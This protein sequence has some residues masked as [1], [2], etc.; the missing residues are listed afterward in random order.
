M[1]ASIAT[2]ATTL[3]W[4]PPSAPVGSG[5]AA[6]STQISYNGQSVGQLDVQP[7]TMPGSLSIPLGIIQ[8]LKLLVI[9][10]L[11]S[12]EVSV[13]FNSISLSGTNLTVSSFSTPL[14]TFTGLSG[15]TAADV[16]SNI[17]VTGASTPANNGTFLI[18]SRLSSSSVTALNASA[19]ASDGNDGAINWSIN[20]GAAAFSVPPQGIVTYAVPTSP[21]T[22][23]ITSVVVVTTTM[24]SV[25]EQISYWTYGD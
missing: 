2:L 16:G 14:V 20:V 25:I 6:F 19:V 21:T 7:T 9:K 13:K 18:T 12:Q 10:N 4:T 24:P 22:V 8:S 23:P 11:L 3:Q 17:V 1:S 15:I 5:S